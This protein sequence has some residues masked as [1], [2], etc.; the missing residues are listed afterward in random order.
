MA[1]GRAKATVGVASSVIVPANDGRTSLLIVN[2]SD[3]DIYLAEG[4]TAVLNEGLRIN[5]AG[6]TYGDDRT[7]IT[8]G[9]WTG[10]I[11]A[12][13]A[14]GGKNVAIMERDLNR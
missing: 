8:S 6:G 2:D 11:A 3:T 4:P 13:A 10:P 5:A 9:M 1:L 14:A 7:N 12:I